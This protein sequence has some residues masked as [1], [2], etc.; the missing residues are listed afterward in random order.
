[1]S[2]GLSLHIGLDSVNPAHYVGW[3][4]RLYGCERDANDMEW[5]ADSR[6]FETSKL[7]TSKATAGAVIAAI[8]EAARELKRGDIFFLSYSGHGGAVPDL[9]E[10]DELDR[11]DE[12]WVAYDRQIVDDELYAHWSR[13]RPGVRIVLLSDCCHGG[14]VT[15]NRP[16]DADVPDPVATRDVAAAQ[17]PLYRALPRDVMV[18]TYRANCDLYDGFQKDLPSSSA[19]EADVGATVLAFLGCQDDQLARDGFSNGLF[20]ENLLAIWDSGAWKG[21]HRAFH[22]AIRSRMPDAQQ[23]NYKVVGV[24]NDDFER[25]S[26]FTIS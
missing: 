6:E 11:T 23:P 26:P 20:T 7:L 25:Q 16:I 24:E 17:S 22:E 8:D 12:T 14:A 9:N 13:F 4:G 18:A 2:R 19:S 10:E 21:G 1:M 3:D 5:L 15:V